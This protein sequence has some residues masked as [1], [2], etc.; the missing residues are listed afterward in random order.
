MPTKAASPE[1][2][3][4]PHE[5]RV[6]A[7]NE[8]RVLVTGGAGF[9]GSSTVARLLDTGAYVT[10]L[11]DFFTGLEEN[12]PPANDRM[13][14]VRG[15]VTDERIVHELVADADYVIHMAARNIIVSTKNPRDDYATNIGGTLNVLMAARDSN[16][17]RVVY[18]SSASVYGNARYLPINEDDVTNMLSPYAVSKYGGENYCKA[19]F[20]SY[21]VPVTSVRYSNV[22]GPLQRPENPYCGVV[23]KF[24]AAAMAG[25]SPIIHGDGEQTRDYTYIADAV[26][27]TLLAAVSPRA[28]GQVYNVGT[29]RET[30][31]NQLADSIVRICGRDTRP[32]HLDRRDIDNIRRRV[33][34]I[35]KARRELRWVP[36][37]TLSSGLRETYDWLLRQ[38]GWR[39]PKES[40]SKADPERRTDVNR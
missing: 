13:K 14:V 5:A 38:G 36:E 6:K 20:E 4:R 24:F 18:T 25:Q 39:G 8:Q 15:S 31:V 23:A 29:G 2:T 19:F 37:M 27:A 9:V 12:L 32:Q 28:E 40:A 34:N 17:R 16:V 7:L 33:L 3:G 35:E 21:G 10:V 1:L 22:Y 30:T 26:E 11:D